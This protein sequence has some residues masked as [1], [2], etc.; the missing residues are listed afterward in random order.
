MELQTFVLEFEKQLEDYNGE[1]LTGETNFKS[2]PEWDSMNTL[3]IIAMID[4]KYNKQI[5]AEDI[6]STNTISELF[7]R[8]QSL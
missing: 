7:S 8:I 5:T 4:H 3:A 1:S 2:L 6:E